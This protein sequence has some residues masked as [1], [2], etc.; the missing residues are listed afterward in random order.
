LRCQTK[1]TKIIKLVH[2]G[3]TDKGTQPENNTTKEGLRAGRIPQMCIKRKGLVTLRI[4]VTV[5][6]GRPLELNFGK[7]CVQR[8]AWTG[9]TGCAGRR[10][11]GNKKKGEGGKTSIREGIKGKLYW[12]KTTPPAKDQGKGEPSIK[13]NHLLPKGKTSA[14][15]TQGNRGRH[16]N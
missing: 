7:R 15:R 11:R 13:G 5:K 2:G 1:G 3:G 9:N 10:K 12:L 14:S 6:G 16:R 4:E 8:A